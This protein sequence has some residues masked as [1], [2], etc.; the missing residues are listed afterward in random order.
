MFRLYRR[1][2]AIALLTLM[3]MPLAAQTAASDDSDVT[4]IVTAER[5]SQPVTESISSASVVTAKQIKESGAQTVADALRAVPGITIIQNGELGALSSASIRGTTTAQSLVLIDGQRV[6]SSAF[7]AIADLAKIPADSIARIEIIRGPV[8]SLYGSDAIGGVI[9][10]ITK[11]PTVD[12]GEATLGFGTNDRAERHLALRGAS[13]SVLWQVAGSVP[14]FTGSRPNSKFAATDLSGRLTLPNE[15]GWNISLNGN[16]YHD[17]LGLPGSITFPSLND[18]QLW[19]RQ[20]L[21]LSATR[22][23]AGGQFE[24]RGYT[25]QQRLKEINP[26]WFTDT[27]ITGDTKAAEMTYSRNFGDHQMVFGTEYRDENYNDMENQVLI[28]DKRITNRALFAQDRMPIGKKMDL[29]AGARLD[30][31]S[32][33]GSHVTPRVGITR[34]FGA[35]TRVRASYSE[36]FRAPSLVE[37]FYNNF[38]SHG[39]PNL[40]PERSSQY[41]VGVNSKCGKNTFDLA[42]FTSRIRDQIAF[43]LIDPVLFTGTWENLERARQRGAEF[44][45]SRP[46][47]KTAGIT[48]AYTYIDALNLAKD[49]R[50]NGIPYNQVGVTM[51]RQIWNC[52]LSLT[53]RFVDKRLFGPLTSPSYALFDLYLA[54]RE[55]GSISPYMV[56]RNLADK[57]YDEVAGYPAEGRSFELGIRSSW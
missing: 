53:G 5:T 16:I 40:K 19:N 6:T 9:N 22:T 10:I 37:L 21:G 2:A 1:G 36:G 31:H 33:A 8:S 42:V 44:T 38:G 13:D 24:I 11:T 3:C 50:L 41:E 46:M 14:S 4:I 7:G 39:N 15:K 45:W 18:R 30:D 28:Q 26:D 29:V 52:D 55:K 43:I 23:I 47:G 12:S 35:K 32:T 57:S 27:L 54:K 25:M 51:S 34:E 49:K 48:L 20:S 56:V 17:K